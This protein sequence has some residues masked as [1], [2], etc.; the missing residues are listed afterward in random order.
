MLFVGFNEAHPCALT[1][2]SVIFFDINLLFFCMNLVSQP[3]GSM[4][5]WFSIDKF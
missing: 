5:F 1:K 3:N 4:G 2:I